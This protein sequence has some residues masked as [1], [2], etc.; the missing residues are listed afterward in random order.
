MRKILLSEFI[1]SEILN[2]LISTHSNKV[3]LSTLFFLFSFQCILAQS[4]ISGKIVDSNNE[5]IPFAH[6]RLE[7]TNIGTI[8]ND[9]GEFK[10]V[11]HIKNKNKLL[12]ISSL[13]YK[14]EKITL[15]NEHQ[16]ITLTEDV[17]QLNEVVIVSKDYAK[18]LIEKAINA[19]PNNYP[20]ADERHTGFFRET[21]TWENEKKPIYI[22]EAVIDA[23]K[24]GYIKR[25]RSGDVK[26]VELRKYESEEL[27]SL[28]FRIYAG[29]HHIHR[30]DIVARREAFLSNTKGYK[31]RIID[32][33]RQNEKDIY[34]VL[35]EKKNK[36]SAYVYIQEET[37]AIVKAD[38]KLNSDYGNLGNREFF[39]FTVTYEQG[40][41]KRWRFMNSY[42]RTAF[43]KQGKILNLT[44]EY[45]TTDIT[46]SNTKIP[47]LE[48]LQFSEILLDKTKEYNPDF[49]NNYTIIT[50]N[51]ISESLFKSVD[52][53]KVNKQSDN[54]PDFVKRMTFEIGLTWTALNTASNTINY[55]NSVI[56]I[57]QNNNAINKGSVSFSTSIFYAV[58]PNFLI[59]Y[60]NESK[61]SRTGINSNDFVI[62]GK[63]NLNPNGRPINISPRLHFGY[64]ELGY[65][66][67]QYNLEEDIEIDGKEIN[68]EKVSVFLSQR[69]LRV[70]PGLVLSIESSKHVSFLISTSYNLHLN[71]KN[72]LVFREK[73]EAGL[74]PRKI[75]L[76][77]GQENLSIE[78][79]Q[80]S[81]FE[82]TISINAGIAFRF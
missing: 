39:N 4:I 65:Y 25:N 76:E 29:S 11:V 61:I 10:L 67:K 19:I 62:A 81:L 42:Y 56:N 47:Y 5:P 48:R 58:T 44:S 26:L 52:Y 12:I 54:I 60:A 1:T 72:G 49:W 7:N 82:N 32:T 73:G 66:L 30:F 50:P 24:K 59:G 80:E 34:K 33:L 68:S 38:I 57:Q 64:H 55:N 23:I 74:F 20:I 2:K 37:F 77:N 27:D 63:F 8:S 16:A 45:V 13:G 41:D 70:K 9:I 31:Y 17:T 79:N 71:Q 15:N 21:T 53:T 78:T 51:E 28:N 3:I 22:N 36:N 40:E 35:V 69:G 43:K 18:E 6:I 75:F 14:T 46:P